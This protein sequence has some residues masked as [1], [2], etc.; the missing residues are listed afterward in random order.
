MCVYLLVM[1]EGCSSVQGL[2]RWGG[3]EAQLCL[4]GS[5]AT[6]EIVLQPSDVQLLHTGLTGWHEGVGQ[7]WFRLGFVSTLTHSGGGWQDSV[8]CWLLAR[9]HPDHMG[10]SVGQIVTQQLA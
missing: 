4:L 5:W 9:D 10:P 3:S 7:G 1:P 8:P 6:L 2:P